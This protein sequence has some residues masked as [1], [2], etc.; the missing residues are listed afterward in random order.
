MGARQKPPS[1]DI[2]AYT[3][4]ELISKPLNLGQL[5]GP[6]FDM[7]WQELAQ[8]ASKTLLKIV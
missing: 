4:L 1:G 3:E 8:D 7:E 2:Y 5:A 6:T